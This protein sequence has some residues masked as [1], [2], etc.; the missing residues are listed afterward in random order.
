[1]CVIGKFI[2]IQQS[3]SFI[4][5]LYLY[6][7]WQWCMV[8]ALIH[9]QTGASGRL[10]PVCSAVTASLPADMLIDCTR[11]I[12]QITHFT[13]LLLFAWTP[14]LPVVCPLPQIY[15]HAIIS[16]IVVQVYH[17]VSNETVSIDVIA[18]RGKINTA[19]RSIGR[20]SI[21]TGRF[22]SFLGNMRHRNH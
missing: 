22:W 16:S 3:C 8:C 2:C 9:F 4:V 12:Y 18:A 20:F 13:A 7:V 14:T 6:S 5:I 10:A 11:Y 19:H 17:F 15:F 1:M 21:Q